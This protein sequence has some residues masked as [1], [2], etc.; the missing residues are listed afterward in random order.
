MRIVCEKCQARYTI[1]DE[2]ARGRALRV[3]CKKCQNV[4]VVRPQAVP[5][6]EPAEDPSSGEATLVASAADVRRLQDALKQSSALEASPP[7]PPPIPPPV[8]EVEWHV[9]VGGQQQGPLP[10][11]ALIAKIEARAVNGRT[12]VWSE[13]LPDWKRIDDVPELS[14]YLPDATDVVS[15]PKPAPAAK[16]A[17]TPPPEAEAEPAREPTPE[18]SRPEP[19]PAK[20]PAREE[21]KAEP[22]KEAAA[23][24]EPEPPAGEVAPSGEAPAPEA[25]AAAADEAA[26][27]VASPEGGAIADPFT[28]VPDAP[29]LVQHASMGEATRF[30]IAQ[31]GIKKQKSP[32]RIASFAA[33]AL[34]L[35]GSLV[36]LLSRLGVNLPVIGRH[37]GPTKYFTE[38]GSDD[39]AL[40]AKLLGLHGVK[41]VHPGG[42]AVPG[43]RST[44]HGPRESG[45]L[46]HKEAQHVEKIGDSERAALAK[47]YAHTGPADLH[48][49]ASSGSEATPAIDRPD[50]PLNPQQVAETIGHYQNS[51]A[52]CINVE[53]KRNPAFRGGKIKIVT[54]IMSSG[55]VRQAEIQ[56]EDAALARRLS[57]SA[58]GTCLIDATRRMVFPTFAGDPFDVEIPLVLGASM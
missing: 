7:P 21:P 30:V 20:K 44:S 35:V 34:F 11:A 46:A 36:F 13:L 37:A 29:D 54:T 10:K 15:V 16:S 25:P 9:I 43:S 12:Y 55:L 45:P 18:Q 8:D 26:I 5:A 22:A 49:P 58:I 28:Q 19:T 1:P 42:P 3:R 40:R 47:L 48:L 32:L 23:S 53:L 2:K 39:A 6:P 51:Y 4:M 50:A 27:P 41:S 52:N 38:N 24:E 14:G 57:N 56:S 31:S 17:P 33:A